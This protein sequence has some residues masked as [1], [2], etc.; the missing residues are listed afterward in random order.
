MIYLIIFLCTLHAKLACEASAKFFQLASLPTFKKWLGTLLLQNLPDGLFLPGPRPRT[1][2][3]PLC[4]LWPWAG[5]WLLPGT[6]RL[7]AQALSK[8]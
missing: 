4:Y 3:P 7:L 6:P 2:P 8:S 1:P 5:F